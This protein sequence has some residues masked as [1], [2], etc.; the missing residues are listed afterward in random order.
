MKFWEKLKSAI[1]SILLVAVLVIPIVLQVWGLVWT[2]IDN[3]RVAKSERAAD[4]YEEYIETE[5]YSLEDDYFDLQ[6]E[7]EDLK[8][9]LDDAYDRIEELEL[10]ING[11]EEEI[12][13]LQMGE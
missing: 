4:E 5:Y 2:V 10:K 9:E 12:E 8:K 13:D 3:R 11:L 1:A 6:I 7:N